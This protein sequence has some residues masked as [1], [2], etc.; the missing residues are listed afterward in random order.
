MRT[1]VVFKSREELINL[2]PETPRMSRTRQELEAA[3]E[4]IREHFGK[5]VEAWQ[6]SALAGYGGH[7]RIT[8]SD[9]TFADLERLS[10]ICGGTK[11]I[12]VHHEPARGSE[13]TPSGD[14]MEIV[15]W[16]N[17]P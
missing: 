10:E 9:V 15:V 11:D 5:R 14:F 12:N 1:P 4:Q 16:A 13:F 7:I 2:Y 3:T 8:L 17:T 6:V